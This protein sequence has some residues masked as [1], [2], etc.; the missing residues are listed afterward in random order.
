MQPKVAQ[1]AWTVGGRV[2][3]EQVCAVPGFSSGRVILPILANGQGHDWLHSEVASHEPNLD[4]TVRGLRKLFQPV[5]AMDNDM[6][7]SVRRLTVIG[8]WVKP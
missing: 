3:N 6:C 7:G 1:M 4:P 2:A 5:E 8:L